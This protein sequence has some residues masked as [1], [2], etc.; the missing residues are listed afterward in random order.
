MIRRSYHVHCS[1]D[2]CSSRLGTGQLFCKD[3]YF[4][5]PRALR[6]RLWSAW[7][8]AMECYRINLTRDEQEERNREYQA[9]FQD[10]REHLRGA[11]RTPASSMTTVATGAS[12][13][14][15]RFVEGRRL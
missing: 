6:D 8:R 1:A 13:E 5:L 10:C 7:R 2:G 9:A 11:P 14:K 3:H 12:G 15:V 4:S